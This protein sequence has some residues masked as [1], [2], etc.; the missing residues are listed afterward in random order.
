MKK[1][2]IW[3]FVDNVYNYEKYGFGFLNVYCEFDAVELVLRPY[4]SDSRYLG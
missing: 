1:Y 3:N 4:L 2:D